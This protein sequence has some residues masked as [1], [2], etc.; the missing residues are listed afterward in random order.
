MK[1]SACMICFVMIFSLCTAQSYTLK[2]F[3]NLVKEKNPDYIRALLSAQTAASEYKADRI[4]K[5]FSGS[6]TAQGG[7]QAS[8]FSTSSVTSAAG[9]GLRSGFQAPAGI[10]IQADS[11]YSVLLDDVKTDILSLSASVSVPIFVNG[12]LIDTSLTEAANYV[13]VESPYVQALTA[14]EQAKLSVLDTVLKLALDTESLSR[15][16]ILAQK[17]LSLAE[18]EAVIAKIQWESGNIGFS[19]F[20][21]AQKNCDELTILLQETQYFYNSSLERLSAAVGISALDVMSL[22][23]PSQIIP[24]EMR[25]LSGTAVDIQLSEVKVTTAKMNSTLTGSQY[26]PVLSVSGKAAF[27]N[28]FVKSEGINP[29]PSW[30]AS[31]SVT[32][33]LPTGVQ[34]LREKSA[35]LRQEEAEKEALSVRQNAIQQG[36]SLQDNYATLCEREQLRSQILMQTK[37]RY[38]EV[39]RAYE[40]ETATAVDIHRALLSVLEAESALKDEGIARFKAALTLYAYYGIDPEDLLMF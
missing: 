23:V 10:K 28:T 25:K 4:E 27:P 8:D 30:S 21:K 2:D 18:Q 16:L 40:T 38:K 39:E 7:L 37:L 5:V 35:L 22:T 24:A 19:D 17:R 34:K 26:A 12:K 13:S 15:K 11:D 29:D 36:Q 3:L 33:P 6:L 20:D 9:A 31:V 1:R 14:A 32:I